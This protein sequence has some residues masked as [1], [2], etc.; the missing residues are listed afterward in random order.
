[1]ILAMAAASAGAGLIAGI[2]PKY[3]LAVAVG[4]IF[5][6]V[7][8]ENVTVGL[9]MLA[10]VA[11]VDAQ[12]ALGVAKLAGGVLA[13]SWLATIMIRRPERGTFVANHQVL[14]YGLVLFLGWITLSVAWAEQ[15]GPALTSIIRYLPNMLLIPIAYD[16]L[17]ER[18]HAVWLL[19]TIAGAA[20]VAA[21]IG[22]V[23]PPPDPSSADFG[24][25]SGT[26]GDAN[27]FAAALV[28]GLP[29]LVAF[30]VRPETK[31]GIRLL[32][33]GAAAMLVLALLLTLSRGGLVALGAALTAAVVF[34]GRWRARMFGAAIAMLLVTVVYFAAFASLPARE[35]V[36]N[37]GGGSGRLDVWTI[38]ERMVSAHPLRG[39][40]TG[41]FE[42][43][44]VHYL[45]RPGLI[46][47]SDFI[48]SYPKVAHN[49][50]L[51]LAAE[52]GVPATA[53]F[54]AIALFCVLCAARAAGNF[55]R[56]NAV[57]M[58]LLVRGALV[59]MIGY[60]AAIFFITETVSK[61]LWLL[62]ALG[63][64]LLAVSRM[65]GPE[66]ADVQKG[67]R[68]RRDRRRRGPRETSVNLR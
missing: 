51:Q 24:R 33:L 44:S 36:T 67:A 56:R 57:G 10:V 61:V 23:Q 17:Q 31:R 5:L 38:G 45:L 12:G 52:L 42:I 58:E 11:I 43:S 64:A 1:L 68:A 16:A 8:L 60:L 53:L 50:Y 29:L 20:A 48:I 47:R 21:A 22:I 4:L 41:N 7:A 35:R 49:T 65:V 54:M 66:P 18:R 28:A 32:A 9:C 30:G 55:A 6:I 14:T 3:G 25:A 46:Q 59:G 15:S 27:E 26:F 40:G 2:S 34:G 13:V 62:L 19:A 37:V 63:P 39:V